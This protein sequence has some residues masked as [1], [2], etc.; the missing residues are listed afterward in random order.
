MGQVFPSSWNGAI[1]VNLVA[2]ALMLQG[3]GANADGNRKPPPPPPSIMLS[4]LVPNYIVAGTGATNVFVNGSGFTNSS[5]VQWNGTA[6][7]TTFGTNQILTASITSSLLAKPGGAQITV[8]DGSATSNPLSFGVA[9]PAAASAGV[10][11]TITAAP[12]E[13]PANGDS[14]VVPSI[15]ANGRYVAFQSNATN[16]ASGPVSGYQEIYERDTCVGAPS[17]CVPNTLRITVTYNGSPVNFH[18]LDSAISANGRYIA[19]DSEATNI[20]PNTS[21]CGSFC[22]FLRDTCTGAPAG[23]MPSTILITVASDGSPAGGANPSMSP[24]GRYVAFNSSSANMVPGD[25]GGVGEAFVRDTCLGAQLGCIPSNILISPSSSGAQDNANT[26][27]PATNAT[28]RYFAFQS[29]ATNLIPNNSVVPGNFWRDTCI[30]ASSC[31]PTTLRADL[32][33]S[34][35]QPN[36]S[37]SNTLIPAITSDGRLVAFSSTATNLVSTNVQGHANAYVRDTCTGSTGA[38]TPTTSLIS[39]ANDGSVGNCGSPSQGL[40]MTPDGRFVAFDSIATNLTP[41]DNF[42]ACGFEDIFVRDTCF[43]VS[44]GCTPSTVRVSVT[45]TPN[46]QTPGNSISGLPAISADG[47]Y[48]VFLS[49]AT[50]LMPGMAGNGHTMVYLAKTGF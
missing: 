28:G 37:V 7:P 18:S 3:C 38:C 6:L 10:T 29:W 30:G 36:N 41:D 21:G 26:G 44:S 47:H 33:A 50:N 9:S 11:A 40:S 23:C 43:G 46:P 49:G 24:D 15:S 14:L 19:F 22:V 12:D 20:L 48:V 8:K 5:V 42:P 34:G 32:T 27:L 25:A 39:L 4:T 16:I 35:A 17:G 45:N 13:S 2:M 1:A 31:T